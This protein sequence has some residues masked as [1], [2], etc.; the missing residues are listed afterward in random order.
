MTRQE[1]IV[2]FEKYLS[3]NASDEEVASLLQYRDELNV[4]D[5]DNAQEIDNQLKIQQKIFS[6]IERT[7]QGQVKKLTSKYWWSAAAAVL[8]FVSAALFVFKSHHNPE[9]NT[10]EVLTHT[11]KQI[12]PGGNKAT[13]TLANGSTINLN[14]VSDGIIARNGKLGIIE[15]KDGQLM[16]TVG[17]GLTEKNDR[18]SFNTINVPRGGQYQVILPDGTDVWLNSESSLRYPIKFEGIERHVELKGEA[19]F[20]V[21]KNKNMPFIV[22]ANN[23]N[24]TVL[25]THFNVMA[26]GDESSVKT[27]L[28]EGSVMLKSHNKQKTLVPGQQATAANGDGKIKVSY[29]NTADAI[30]WKNGY[31]AFRDENLV[32]IMKKVARWYDVDVEY[33]DDV[34]QVVFGGSI[35]RAKDI[36]EL[37][38]N[39]QLTGSAHF[40]IEGRRVIVKL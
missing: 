29:V 23:V 3:G 37:L 22:N 1:Y 40:K 8:L 19:Y 5:Y 38:N 35:S 12:V 18:L 9:I 6:K 30:S 36:E 21:A 15:K 7:R 27:T 17:N 10:N 2:L 26:Y 24:I 14:Q 25:G 34:S 4:N 28:L 32:S 11:L 31:F 16:Y 33:Q 39:I 20:E 13:L